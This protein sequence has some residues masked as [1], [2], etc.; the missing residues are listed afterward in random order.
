MKKTIL[1]ASGL[2]L[3]FNILFGLLLSKYEWFNMGVNCGVIVLNTALLF[4]IYYINFRDAFRITFSFLFAFLAFVEFILGCL[5]PQQWQDNGCLMAI[6]ILLFIK[7]LLLV[8]TNF[9]SDK[10]KQ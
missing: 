6:V 8:V 10:I 9:V 1:I 7:L 2:V 3:V 4:G 5:M